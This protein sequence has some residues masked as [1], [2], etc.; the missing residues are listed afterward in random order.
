[1]LM[2]MCISVC[3]SSSR[4]KVCRTESKKLC[5]I[6]LYFCSPLQT[7]IQSTVEACV[8]RSHENAAKPQHCQ[9]HLRELKF[10]TLPGTSCS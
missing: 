3:G 8:A 7:A 10:F 4:N 5:N 2:T 6:I 9:H 1:M